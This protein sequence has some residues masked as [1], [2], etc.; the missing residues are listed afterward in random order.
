MGV[1]VRCRWWGA[2]SRHIVSGAY[3]LGAYCLQGILSLGHIVSGAYC[4]RAYCL[5][6]IFSLGL[7]VSGAYCLWGILSLGHSVFG[8]YCLRGILSPGRI[9]LGHIFSGQI[10]SGTG[11][12][13]TICLDGGNNWGEG[14]TQDKV[15][16]F[17][18]WVRLWIFWTKIVFGPK[19]FCTY[20]FF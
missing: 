7:I 16:K 12:E 10:V 20:F 2:V 5:R 9:V 13:D 17:S 4:L 1:G 3:C 19:I 6:G 18:T 11:R 8:A 15:L 14:K